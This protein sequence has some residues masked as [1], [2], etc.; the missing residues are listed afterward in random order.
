MYICI[1][2]STQ[3]S[4]PPTPSFPTWR[5]L[6]QVETT[7]DEGI[8]GH[9]CNF[10]GDTSPDATMDTHANLLNER[11]MTLN[12]YSQD[13]DDTNSGRCASFPTI[14]N[15]GY[16]SRRRYIC[17]QGISHIGKGHQW[18]RDG[19]ATLDLGVL[20]TDMMLKCQHEARGSRL[21]HITRLRS[22][23]RRD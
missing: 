1:H 7:A 9:V 14:L 17:P 8:Y 3:D 12:N 10:H 5:P 22:D 18:L 19:P 21:G 6:N 16:I 23:G 13:R 11:N 15:A 2:M 4:S 20:G